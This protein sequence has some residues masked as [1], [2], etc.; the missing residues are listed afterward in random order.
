MRERS[1]AGQ[2][3]SGAAGQ[4]GSGAAGQRGRKVVG[5]EKGVK[6]VPV[7]RPDSGWAYAHPDYR[8]YANLT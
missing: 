7:Y 6:G 3:G 1:W 4:R 2:R 8:G 5:F